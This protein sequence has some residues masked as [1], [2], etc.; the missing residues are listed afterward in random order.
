MSA[1][2]L[3]KR[4]SGA[5]IA[6][7]LGPRLVFFQSLIAP[8]SLL[9]RLQFTFEYGGSLT[10]SFRTQLVFMKAVTNQIFVVNKLYLLSSAQRRLVQRYIEQ[11]F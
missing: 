9:G 5:R 7:N 3:T 10:T 1:I 11:T 4:C 6:L 2:F 8:C